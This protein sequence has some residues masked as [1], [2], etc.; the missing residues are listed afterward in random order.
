[1]IFEIRDE[2]IPGSAVKKAGM[3]GV[4]GEEFLDKIYFLTDGIM[5]QQIKEIS[6]VDGT[7]LQ[8]WVK[9]GWIGNTVNKRY[10]KNQLA[11]ILIIN[12]LRPTMQLERIDFLLRYING[13]IN[14]ER[15]DIIPESRLYGYICRIADRLSDLTVGEGS[16][17]ALPGEA[18]LEACI[19]NELAEYVG[20]VPGAKER[21]EKALAVILTAYGASLVSGRA[22]RLFTALRSPAGEAAQ[23]SERT[24]AKEE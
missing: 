4:T 9:R 18:S 6:G 13:T 23:P 11:R 5:R 8:N 16:G 14:D 17:A 21:L 12:M 1:M 24:P 7:T 20:P 3:A 22:M 2:N 10:S 15:D 19:Q